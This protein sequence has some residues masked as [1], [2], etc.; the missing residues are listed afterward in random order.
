[1]THKLTGEES[2]GEGLCLQPSYT[3][4]TERCIYSQKNCYPGNHDPSGFPYSYTEMS[5]EDRL[6][7]L[8]TFA[9]AEPQVK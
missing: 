9:M 4:S 5:Q 8:A 6:G 7:A 2:A 1:M 3:A